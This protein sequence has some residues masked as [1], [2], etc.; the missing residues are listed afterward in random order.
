MT[1]HPFLTEAQIAQ[2]IALYEEHG[3]DAVDEICKRVIVPNMA[4]IDAK[5]GQANDARYLAYAVVYALSSVS[6][7]N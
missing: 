3:M 4:A 1:L 2:A 5:I 7:G 6:E